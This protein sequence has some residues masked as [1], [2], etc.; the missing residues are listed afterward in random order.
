MIYYL[1]RIIYALLFWSLSYCVMAQDDFN[2]TYK[3]DNKSIR[4]EMVHESQEAYYAIGY[5]DDY[6][7]YTVGIHVS[8]HDKI[9]AEVLNSTYFAIDS[10]WS[11]LEH[12]FDVYE[13]DNSLIFGLKG[14]GK[15]HQLEYDMNTDQI[16]I[17]DTVS[18]S[19]EDPG[20]YQDD[21]LLFNDTTLYVVTYA[22]EIDSFKFGLFFTY[23]DGTQES[24]DIPLTDSL[25]RF[26]QV[27]KRDNGN[28]VLFGALNGE[29]VFWDRSLAIYEYDKDLNE[30]GRFFTP[31]TDG[32]IN[33]E[34]FLPINEQ[35]ILILASHYDWDFIRSRY[36]YSHSILRYHIDDR[37]I[38]WS[39]N[40][41]SPASDGLSGGKIVASHESGHYLYC[42]GA[43]R[44][45]STIDSLSEVGRVVKID[46]HGE[47]IWQ[48]DYYYFN[49]NGNINDFYDIIA[50]SDGNYLLGGNAG[51]S[52]GHHGWLLKI[53][54][55]GE[56]LGDSL[57]NV[58]WTE[59]D[60]R[61]DIQIYPNPIVDHIYI[62]QNAVDDITYHLY[63]VQGNAIDHLNI[64]A[65][66]QG[67]IWDVSDLISGS[68]FIRMVK[69]GKVIGSTV[70]IKQGG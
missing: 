19:I 28:Y 58:T 41:G 48:K 47:Q 37:K 67:V 29:N 52:N 7:G 12:S 69:E 36:A 61:N 18:F 21:M 30:L 11:F 50:T 38:L 62:N 15:L 55:S 57:V 40:F 32:Y 1:T 56:L 43:V 5:S 25:N 45:G 26:G 8:K 16:S 24:I 9:T 54:E 68:Y 14:E 34:N 31:S 13:V 10:V 51:N 20:L 44:E 17:I 53:N 35:E 39:E 63:D 59:D 3:Y 27:M 4:N 6:S 49:N 70:L 2:K 23:P 66:D 65:K 33:V 60:W 64:N 22:L 46:E 42:T